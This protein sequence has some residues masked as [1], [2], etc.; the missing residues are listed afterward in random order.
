MGDLLDAYTVSSFAKD[1]VRKLHLQ[2]EVD[3]ARALIEQM[4][5]V[6]PD[7]VMDLVTGNHEQRVEKFLWTQAPALAS[8]RCLRLA[9]LLALD[10]YGI[11]LHGR[12]GFMLRPKF[13][14]K[15]GDAVRRHSGH[16][17]KAEFE[18]HGVS[19]VSGHTHRVGSY[20][21]RNDA[22]SFAWWELGCLCNLNA[23]YITGV[24]NWQQAIAVGEFAVGGNRYSLDV[25]RIPEQR[26]VYQGY[27]Y[28]A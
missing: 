22:G 21:L 24:A 2:E 26:L 18:K 14:V 28:S 13:R 6:C 1:P 25:V 19:G 9:E 3:S 10:S 23:E 20:E 12:E 8:L 4:R 16:S 27:D 7:A 11:T 5:A 17:A 15:H